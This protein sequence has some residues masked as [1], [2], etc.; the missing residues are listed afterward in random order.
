M[1]VELFSRERLGVAT[2][3]NQH[4]YECLM[5]E[6]YQLLDVIVAVFRA[7]KQEENQLAQWIEEQIILKVYKLDIVHLAVLIAMEH[8]VIHPEVRVY[9]GRPRFIGQH[10]PQTVQH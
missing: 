10:I 1:G 8:D 9:N 5:V 4:G 3:S 7:G 6:I 2:H